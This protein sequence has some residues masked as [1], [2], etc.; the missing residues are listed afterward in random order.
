[1]TKLIM[2]AVLLAISW[3]ALSSLERR[4][5]YVP[6]RQITGTPASFGWPYEETVLA[7]RDGTRINGWFIPNK[8]PWTFLV[9]HGNAGNM[10]QRLDKAQRLR[11]TSSSVLLFDYRGYGKS[12]GHPSKQGT[13]QDA[14]VAYQYLVETRKIAPARII[15]YGESLGCAMA[16]EMARRHPAAGL[17]LESPFTSTVAMGELIYPWLPVRWLVRYHYDNLS[18]IPR[19]MMPLLIFHSRQDEI[20]PFAM[21][22]ALF[23][24]APEPKKFVELHG[25]HNDGYADSGMLYLEAVQTFLKGIQKDGP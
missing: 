13:Y 7:A 8:G 6:D 11:S 19:L 25:D 4:N 10:S 12:E 2:L 9:C 15:L 23:A 18:K 3:M 1:M 24:A 14:D 20:V 5:L 22:Q 21:G 16:V 17:I